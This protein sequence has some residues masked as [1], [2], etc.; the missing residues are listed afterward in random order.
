MKCP[1]CVNGSLVTKKGKFGDF[2]A[3]DQYPN[4]KYIHKSGE[5]VEESKP[6]QAAKHDIVI[7]KVEKPHSYEFGQPGNRH[8]VYYGDI[9]EL[10]N[11]VQALEDNGLV[12]QKV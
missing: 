4:C 1:K 10:K 12:I 3:C 6:V 2:L 9:E 11:H 8:K 5:K 7:T